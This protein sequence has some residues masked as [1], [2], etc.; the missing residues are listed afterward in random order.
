MN[1]IGAELRRVRR[2]KKLSQIE[3]SAACQR[4]GWDVSRETIT[5][6]ETHQRL[7]SDYEVYL[8]ASALGV[9]PRELLPSSPDLGPFLNSGK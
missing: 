5:R 4:M 7:V 8:L 3:L 2:T 1:L 6:I 9:S